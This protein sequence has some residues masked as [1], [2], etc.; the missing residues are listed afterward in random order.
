MSD[1]R[2]VYPTEEAVLRRI[3]VLKPHAVKLT[4]YTGPAVPA[5]CSETFTVDHA[6]SFFPNAAWSETDIETTSPGGNP[7]GFR[8]QDRNHCTSHGVTSTNYSGWVSA[9]E[10]ETRATC[11]AGAAVHDAEWRWERSTSSTPTSWMQYYP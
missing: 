6:V 7:C 3:E 8:V 10:L 4:A 11:P 9:V 1:L 2:P 5:T